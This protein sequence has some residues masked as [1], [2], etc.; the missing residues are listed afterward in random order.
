MKK[1]NQV[2][3]K[4]E[5]EIVRMTNGSCV[6]VCLRKDK[7]ITG[8]LLNESGNITVY[9]PESYLEPPKESNP[10]KIIRTYF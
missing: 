9:I 7:F 2:E 8:K 6:E 4:Q 3:P 10:R 5:K 1:K